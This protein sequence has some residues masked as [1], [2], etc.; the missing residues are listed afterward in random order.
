MV[1]CICIVRGQPLAPQDTKALPVRAAH[2]PVA[3]YFVYSLGH[4]TIGSGK[5]IY[6]VRVYGNI[7]HHLVRG[8]FILA[9][10]LALFFIAV[11]IKLAWDAFQEYT[12]KDKS[13]GKK[14]KG[15]GEVIDLS[16][17]WVDLSDMPYRKRDYI[18]NA[19][20][21]GAFRLIS[22]SLGDDYVVFP[23][24]RLADLLTLSADAPRRQEYL[25]RVKERKV[26]FVI[27]ASA[28]LKPVLV[29]MA[30]SP[31]DGKKKQLV[32][33]FTLLALE[34]AGLPY[35]NMDI[36]NLPENQEFIISLQKAGL[37]L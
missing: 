10:L 19:R 30:G 3:V 14:K 27:C 29:V 36:A 31:S 21:L 28:E 13:A 11:V 16:N 15:Q 1:C 2:S 37:A 23:K 7:L 35:T 4:R 9:Q 22:D 17:A 33:R 32:E 6:F 26:D 25:E 8:V 24:V 5:Q 18:L 12:A 34:A 20:E